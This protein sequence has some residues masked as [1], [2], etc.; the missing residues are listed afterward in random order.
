MKKELDKF[1]VNSTFG[2]GL[3]FAY[4]TCSPQRIKPKQFLK[5]KSL[6]NKLEN[7]LLSIEACRFTKFPV[8]S[9][10]GNGLKFSYKIPCTQK[11]S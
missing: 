5:L 6:E 7:I 10:I 11:W 4:K 9:K 2:S 3:I 1:Q 8:D